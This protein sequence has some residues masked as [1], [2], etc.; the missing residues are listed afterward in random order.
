MIDELR[1]LVDLQKNFDKQL[2]IREELSNPSILK[3]LKT[4]FEEMV[5]ERKEKEDLILELQKKQELLEIEVNEKKEEI[6]GLRQKLQMVR[7][8]K[9]YSEVLNGID[10]IQKILSSKEDEILQTMESLENEKKLF[11]EKKLKWQPIEEAYLEAENKWNEL[12]IDYEAEL[13]SLELEE[14]IIKEK[15][16][17]NYYSLFNKILKLRKRQA[18]VPVVDG[19]CSG[20]HILLRPQQLADV[21]SGNFVIQCDQCQR[22]L[23]VE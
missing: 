10:A 22:I 20:C 12:K 3:E 1:M 9:E 6:K 11:E 23:F 18:V 17:K 4:H 19:S 2:F 14:K 21:K 16:P 15:L 8:Q 13:H 7:N 5:K